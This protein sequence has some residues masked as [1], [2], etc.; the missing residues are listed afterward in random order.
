VKGLYGSTV[1]LEDG[2]KRI[3]D[4]E[5]LEEFIHAPSKLQVKGF[6]PVMPETELTGQQMHELIEFLKTL[7]SP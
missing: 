4:E 6:Q 2:S 5:Y 7:S 3:A 1:E